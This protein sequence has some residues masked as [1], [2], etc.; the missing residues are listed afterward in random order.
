[1]HQKRASAMINRNWEE[2]LRSLNCDARQAPAAGTW[3]ASVGSTWPQMSL[4]IGLIAA[5]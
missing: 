2:L 5:K 1:V 3:R 4:F